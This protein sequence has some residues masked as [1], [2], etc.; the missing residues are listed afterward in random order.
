M[1]P[2][3]DFQSLEPNS[4][5]DAVESLGLACDARIFALNSYENRVYQIGIED[6]T[7]VIGKFY[8]PHRWTDE[9]ILEEHYFSQELA[10]LEIPVIAPLSFENRSLIKY[11]DFRFALFPR[12]GGH[13]PELDN[14]DHLKWMGRF[15]ARIHAAGA[16]SRFQYRPQIDIQ[17]FVIEPSAFLLNNNFIPDYLGNAYDSLL[18]DILKLLRQHMGSVDFRN[19]RLHGDCHQGNI[20]WTDKGPHFVD[21]DDCRMGPAVQD[22]WM[23]LSGTLDEQRKQLD[24]V[25]DGYYEFYDFNPAEAR[26]IETLRT[27]RIIHYAGWLARRWDDPSF[28]L[29]FPWFNTANYWEQHILELREQ[30]ALLQENEPLS[31]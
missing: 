5:I 26:L 19:I 7:P 14:P 23:L 22:I 8:R 28:P 24:D 29:N 20:L 11:N 3:P 25:L 30:F 9:Q 6:Q 4:I 18:A 31:L 1:N 10:E 13:T 2:Q 16:V 15:L 21:F 27:M 17:S 12:K